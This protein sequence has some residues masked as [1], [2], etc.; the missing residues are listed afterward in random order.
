MNLFAVISMMIFM[1]VS[2]VPASAAAGSADKKLGINST[3]TQPTQSKVA[4]EKNPHSLAAIETI[5]NKT[6]KTLTVTWGDRG[7]PQA[8]YGKMGNYGKASKAAALQFL[9]QQAA[10]FKLRPDVAD[11]KLI[12]QKKSPGGEHFTFQQNY[13]GVKVFSGKLSVSFDSQGDVSVVGGDYFDEI[14]LATVKPEINAQT[15]R[16]TL[17]QFVGKSTP[18]P[19]SVNELVVYVDDLNEAHLVYHIIQPMPGKNGQSATYE[20]FVDAVFNSIIGTPRDINKYANGQIYRNGNAMAATGDSNLK[21]TSPVPL[22]AYQI[23]PLQGL[24]S[25]T[26]LIGQYCDVYT[27]TAAGNR[28][29]PDGNGN[30]LYTR[31]TTPSVGAKFDAVNTYFYVDFAQR[32]IQ[33]LGFT[34]IN[35]R[36]VRINVNGV[37]DDNSFYQPNGSGSGDVVLGSGGV[38]DAEDAEVVLHEYGHAI[39]DSSKP[40]IW[41]GD[42]TSG[43]I[44]RTGAMGEGWSDYWAASITTQHFNQAGTIYATALEEWDASSYSSSVPPTI[45][46]I[47]SSKLYP[48]SVVD[49][50]HADGEIWSSTLWQIRDDFIALAGNYAL[51]AKQADKLFLESHF[52]LTSAN[53]TFTDGANAILMAA[54]NLNYTQAQQEA[55]RNRFNERGILSESPAC[56]STTSTINVGSSANGT[57]DAT[58]CISMIHS[59]T[60][61]DNFT[62]QA[63][64][65]TQYTITQNSTAFDAY[66]YLLNGGTVLAQNDDGNGGTNSKI[67]YTPT[68][69]G[70]LTIHAT[71]Y[72][73]NETG[74]YTVAVTTVTSTPAAPSG[75]TASV[76]SSSQI[77]LSWTD[78]STNET[79][80]II[81][82]KTGAA[83]TWGQIATAG[84]NATSYADTGLA[85]ST[86]YVY[87]VRAN[88]AAGTS[89]YS[90]EA[91]AT[92]TSTSLCSSSSSAIAVGGTS[93]GNLAPTDCASRVRSGGTYYYD[94]FTF[95]AVAGTPYTITLNSTAFD[96]YLYL[97]NGGTVLAQNDDGNGGRNSKIVY[98]PTISGT[99]TI[100]TTS[101]SASATGAYTVA[102][103]TV[104]S[105]PAAPSGLTASVASSSQ[106]NL[107]WTDNSTNE[108]GFMIERKTG[109]AGTWGQIATAGV[110]ATSYADTGLAASTNYVYRVRTNNA[111][112]TSSYSNE[113]NATTTST[114]LCSSSSS[115]IAVG[116]TSNGNLAP[117]DCASRV[118]SGG[119]YYYDNFTFQA[120]AGTPYTIT[121]NSTAFDAYLYLLNG[122]TVLA[123]N[124]DGNG[125]RN[126]KIVYTPTISGT[127]TIHTTSYS[128]SA[129]G[130]YTVAVT[131]V[132]STP[133]APSGLTASVASSSQIN[134]SWTDNST[135]ETGFM[136][137]RKTGAAGTWGQIATAGVNAT[138]YADTGL[139][140]STNYVYRVRANNAAGTSS[141][142]NEANATTTSTSLCSSSSS[143]IAVGGTSNGNL[144]PTDCASRVRSGGTYYYDNFTFQAVAG[145]PYTITLNSTAFDAYL[146]LLNGGTV[147]A[148]NDDGN[149]GRNSKIVYTPTISGTLTIHTTSYSASATGAYTVVIT[150][151]APSGLTTSVTLPPG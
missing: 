65:G 49:E 117:T 16:Q 94:N 129:T 12:D 104:T 84:V 7:S 150:T 55:I 9:A 46:S 67:V 1:T 3:E 15:A 139:A 145:T 113:A 90:N 37:T 69:S 121:L 25:T 27:L 18:I 17:F 58:D 10:L 148:Q 43:F 136:I 76:A 97:L 42:S 147:L 50:V 34:N 80:F 57:L 142:S 89:S 118:R 8:I 109:A 72:F 83:G 93:N 70:T 31:N 41:D 48:N 59:G 100:H 141:Y 137:E 13:A 63:V 71:S 61:Y 47:T 87:R 73:D 143:A 39:Q 30:Y 102:V 99:L 98:T 126:S 127:L 146:Y 28:A 6:G 124:D 60:Y 95:Q 74:A 149:G 144:A 33:L 53:N 133:A 86:N 24:T 122:G 44:A 110:N 21:D 130:A 54:Q 66:L 134:L 51:G 23:L 123:Q 82:R 22:S 79:G 40:N 119:T 29:T 135:N 132:T 107:S 88:N 103:T 96:A 11:L 140:A 106:I 64:A 35:N 111:A 68:V 38:D 108:T 120:V 77:N 5:Q 36:S 81:E 20:A 92:T 75:L 151:V 4:F 125:G 116:G 26:G 85:A 112:G 115:A 105:T 78:N 62:F 52:L 2:S 32:Y 91:N 14:N 138:S 45:R 19:A 131:T 128:A 114:S 101:Y 56:S